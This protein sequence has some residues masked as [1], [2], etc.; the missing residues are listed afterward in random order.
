M[1][2]L[3]PEI[4]KQIN[5][6]EIKEL[7]EKIYFSFPDGSPEQR[8]YAMQLRLAKKLNKKEY[9]QTARNKRKSTRFE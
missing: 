8:K 1:D 7:D 4:I 5:D 6:K 3:P 2:K 9:E